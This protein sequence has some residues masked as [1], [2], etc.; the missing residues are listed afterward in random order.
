MTQ[1]IFYLSNHPFRDISLSPL[2]A[3]QKGSKNILYLHVAT[4]LLLS[5][6]QKQIYCLAK[7]QCEILNK[8]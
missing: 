3:N 5:L 8:Q 4:H 1:S 7:T 2:H 6:I